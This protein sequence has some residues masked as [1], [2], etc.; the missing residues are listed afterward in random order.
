MKTRMRMKMRTR[1][2][3]RRRKKTKKPPNMHDPPPTHTQQQQPHNTTQPQTQT[4]ELNQRRQ[5]SCRLSDLRTFVTT[6]TFANI[7]PFVHEWELE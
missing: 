7:H 2:Y 6:A 5:I 4:T 3:W 1:K